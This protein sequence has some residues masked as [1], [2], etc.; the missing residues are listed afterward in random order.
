MLE[1]QLW[2]L[3]ADQTKEEG[4]FFRWRKS[5]SHKFGWTKSGWFR[6]QIWLAVT[7][8][9]MIGIHPALSFPFF[10][11]KLSTFDCCSEDEKWQW[12]LA[13]T[14][15]TDLQKSAKAMV[16]WWFFNDRNPCDSH[17]WM[18]VAT[19]EEDME[20]FTNG[21]KSAQGGWNFFVTM[22]LEV[23]INTFSRKK[24]VVLCVFL[25]CSGKTLKK[26]GSATWS[27]SLSFA[28]SS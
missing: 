27:F 16:L 7:C 6:L 4:N 9:W 8:P 17:R 18:K 5:T 1:K 28:V 19:Q 2:K 21:I 26:Q 14:N 22:E 11:L 20:S 15:K 13:E 25:H 24:A 23:E 10:F 12:C 3:R